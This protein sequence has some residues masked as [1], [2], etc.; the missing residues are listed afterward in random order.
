MATD[1][2]LKLRATLDTAEVQQKLQQL[3]SQMQQFKENTIGS[4][5]NTIN[6]NNVR[7]GNIQGALKSLQTSVERLNQSINKI[8]QMQ[9]RSASF[10]NRSAV[11][12]TGAFPFAISPSQI[13]ASRP[14]FTSARN[15]IQY[16]F[17]DLTQLS[18]DTKSDTGAKYLAPILRDLKRST[19][20]FSTRGMR[21]RAINRANAEIRDLNDAGWQVADQIIGDDNYT[22]FHL[23]EAEAIRNARLR[24][25]NQKHGLRTSRMSDLQKNFINAGRAFAGSQALGMVGNQLAAAGHE[26]AG[27][28]FSGA[29][30]GISAGAMTAMSLSKFAIAG[31]AGIA[32]GIGVAANSI[33]GALI[34][35]AQKITKASEEAYA[36]LTSGK[37]RIAEHQETVALMRWTDKTLASTPE[38]RKVQLDAIKKQVEAAKQEYYSLS[39]NSSPAIID[40]AKRYLD[41]ANN[42]EAG[43]EERIAIERKYGEAV[44][45][46]ANSIDNAK[47]QLDK[48]TE[49]QHTLE[50][51]VNEDIRKSENDKAEKERESEYD[52]AQK[53]LERTASERKRLLEAEQKRLEAEQS[54]N[55]KN[56]SIDIITGLNRQ[57]EQN[58]VTQ[59]LFDIQYDKK[60]FERRSSASS[61]FQQASELLDD[62]RAQ[63]Q[64]SLN[65]ARI[66]A[67][68]AADT[69]FSN[70][71]RQHFLEMSAG[72]IENAQHLAGIIS[73]IE[74]FI[75][76]LDQNG[77]KPPNMQN[78]TSLSQY[79]FSMGERND[80]VSRMEKYYQNVED[81]TRQIRNKL[82]EG[83]KTDASYN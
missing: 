64:N 34:E 40:A 35:S 71:Y 83:I 38:Q 77:I 1:Y 22:P 78:V 81:L 47:K 16:F 41:E 57:S 13:T 42:T 69:S 10:Q 58:S 72:N 82:Q 19:S 9:I 45:A 21:R 55:I 25:L 37:K 67:Q 80:N 28:V 74:G 11:A 15:D 39:D 49:K 17:D 48:L 59:Q 5:K 18:K 73:Q 53:E 46:Y 30:E 66:Q 3:Q 4:S 31:P 60:G 75:Y 50:T 26:T 68:N 2:A 61:K 51:L 14:S 20:I 52:I 12:P 43:S 63:R 24:R 70:E 79:G 7:D 76:N 6:A 62:Y 32:V 27:G 29:T 56:A 65:L 36:I 23:A 44:V 54:L 33:I 8:N